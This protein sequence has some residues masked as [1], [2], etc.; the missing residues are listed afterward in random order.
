MTYLIRLLGEEKSQW[1]GLVLVFLMLLIAAAFEV[2]A[3]IYIGQILDTIID[4]LENHQN[5]AHLMASTN[6]IVLILLAM[7]FAHVP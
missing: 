7:Y 4:G 6:H 3:P 5:M 1:A 2:A